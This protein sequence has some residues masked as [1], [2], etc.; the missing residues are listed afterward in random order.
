M[1]TQD[2]ALDLLIVAVMAH[3]AAC[4]RATDAVS[5]ERVAKDKRTIIAAAVLFV[6]LLQPNAPTS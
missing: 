3:H 1:I 4:L 5:R 2:D 6:A